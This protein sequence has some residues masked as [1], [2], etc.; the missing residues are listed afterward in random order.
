MIFRPLAALLLALPA[1]AAEPNFRVSTVADNGMPK[2]IVAKGASWNFGPGSLWTH[3]SW[4]YAAYWDDQRQVSVARRELPSGDWSVISLPGYKRSEKGDRGKGGKI[5]RGFGDGHE[6][7]S[8]GISPDGVIHLSFDHHLSTLRYRSSKLPVANDPSSHPWTS[9]LF[10]PV[11]DNLGG[12]KIT[13][14]TY[15]SFTSDG[16]RF[17]LYLRLG[18]G[19]G[20]ANSHLFNY[21]AGKWTI[22][23]EAESKIID[24]N[25]SGGD[26]TV[27]AYPFGLVI[28]QGRIHLSWCWRD[29]PDSSTC[30]D[31]CYAYSDDGG[32]TWKSSDGNLVAKRG[33]TFITA[34]T[35]GISAWPIPA[36]TKY[37]NGGSMSV[38]HSGRVHVLV[39]GENGDP[40]YFQRD[41]KSA[42]W[43]R[44]KAPVQGSFVR[45]KANT[46]FV[47]NDGT[48]Y[49]LP[50]APSAPWRKI[51]TAPESLF[52]N[53]KPGRD[54]YR[55]A[56]DAWV[57]TI[58]QQGKKISVVDFPLNPVE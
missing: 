23:T 55:P 2:N 39:R 32:S 41:P 40:A 52:R 11:E 44:S 49:Q 25:W 50:S 47:L 15:P 53:C 1:L 24:L 5:S 30:H 43:T 36:G 16:S 17:F 20:S 33:K 21:R 19:S 38:D 48:L 31:L 18:G 4:Q 46:L 3:K 12:P 28:H 37:I 34:D 54:D 56:H 7:V 51:A 45:G 8:L 9:D 27:N 57:S 13:S 10:G 14:V 22:N 35:P 6:K 42:E 29:T 58:G 26:G